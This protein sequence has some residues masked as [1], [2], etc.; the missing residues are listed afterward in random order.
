M[1]FAAVTRLVSR[2]AAHYLPLAEFS[3]KERGQM[4]EGF[5]RALTASRNRSSRRWDL[6]GLKSRRALAASLSI[7]PNYPHR[8][9]A[10]FVAASPGK[11]LAVLTTSPGSSERFMGRV[12]LVRLPRV[13]EARGNLIELDHASLPFLP[14]RT[15]IVDNVPRGTVR[16]GHAHQ[17]CQQLLV[18]L[19]GRLTV[20]ILFN[21]EQ[22]EVVLDTPEL[23]LYVAPRVWN[24]TALRS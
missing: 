21:D 15:F 9:K 11:G 1:W 12:R 23:A 22:A 10:G 20:E 16:G 18:C 8:A 5:L 19:K 3:A 17:A 4:L 6:R 7:I 2:L 24:S 13:E 14:Q